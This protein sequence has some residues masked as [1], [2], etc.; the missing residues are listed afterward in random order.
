MSRSRPRSWLLLLVVVALVLVAGVALARP[1]GGHSY[2]GGS[3]SSGSSRSSGG[4]GGGGDGGFLVEILIFLV[5]ENPAI[6]IPLII[7]IGVGS[8]GRRPRPT[9]L[10]CKPTSTKLRGL[11]N[12]SKS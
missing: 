2:S 3:R 8:P 4:S 7:I 6:G 9:S 11:A 10:R 5:I 1:G 12:G